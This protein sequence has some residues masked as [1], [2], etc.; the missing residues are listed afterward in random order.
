[1]SFVQALKCSRLLEYIMY[2]KNILILKT[3]KVRVFKSQKK[4]FFI[5]YM[6]LMFFFLIN[7]NLLI[8][9]KNIYR[10]N[11]APGKEKLLCL[12]RREDDFCLVVLTVGFGI[13]VRK[14]YLITQY[15]KLFFV[16]L[17]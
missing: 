8:L 14:K 7:L 6:Y 9:L 11:K 17:K 15:V 3:N 5:I 1:M 12:C 13:G 10:E 16:T 2:I 4:L